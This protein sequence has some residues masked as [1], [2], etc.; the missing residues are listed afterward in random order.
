MFNL[1]I[2]EIHTL[3][4]IGFSRN[5]SKVYLSLIES[6]VVSAGVISKKEGMHRRTVYDTLDAL[7]EKGLVSCIIKDKKR[8]FK[9]TEPAVIS[10]I[11]KE[12]QASFTKIL[13]LLEHKQKTSTQKE[14]ATVYTGRKGI[15][16]VLKSMQES[17]E[18]WTIGSN[19]E[20][21]NILK[22]YWGQNQIVR[23]K[24]GIKVRF[25]LSERLRNSEIVNSVYGN[26]KYLSG[27]H[28]SSIS[29]NIFDN[30]IAI[31]TWGEKPVCVVIESEAV[32]AAF[33]QYFKFLW[34]IGK[35]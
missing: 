7:S 31:I 27:E 16:T 6:G 13:P 23:K 5:E 18:I 12:H 15:I 10:E 32:S 26:I 14:E 21:K 35:K 2:M 11:L 33:R 1:L 9:A 19:G 24:K 8:L 17:K 34:V 20:S 30:K 22:E 3:E 28:D 4:R 29:T 25:L